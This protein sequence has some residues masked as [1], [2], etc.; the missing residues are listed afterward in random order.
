MQSGPS[1]GA[2]GGGHGTQAASLNQQHFLNIFNFKTNMQTN[3][4]QQSSD[5]KARM[6]SLHMI[7]GSS[8]KAVIACSRVLQNNH[9][10]KRI[11]NINKQQNRYQFS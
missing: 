5:M 10:K 7:G 6:R 1:W 9:V 11:Y 2:G 3:R 8:Q 4:L